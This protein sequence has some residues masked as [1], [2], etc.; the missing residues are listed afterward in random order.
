MYARVFS[1]NYEIFKV[2]YESIFMVFIVFSYANKTDDKPSSENDGH[3]TR[4]NFRQPNITSR[5][6]IKNSFIF[7]NCRCTPLLVRIMWSLLC[8]YR[9]S[10]IY[11]TRFCI[12]NPRVILGWVPKWAIEANEWTWTIFSYTLSFRW[13]GLV[14]IF[15]FQTAIIC[16][17]LIIFGLLPPAQMKY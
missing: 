9:C 2:V 12:T 11:Q 1:V 3:R 8:C 7:L 5:L 15:H 16:Q 4:N 10:V 17:V 6:F 13:E 14:V